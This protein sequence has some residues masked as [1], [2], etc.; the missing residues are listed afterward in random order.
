MKIIVFDTETT[1][2]P[3]NS[4]V[5]A[6]QPYI[7]QFGAMVI[8]CDLAARKLKEVQRIDQLLRPL[9]P[10]PPDASR[11]HGIRDADV[12][13]APTFAEYVDTLLG[14]FASSDAAVGHNIDFDRRII[15]NE[16]LR[17]GRRKDFLP[18]QTF[19]TM[20]AGVDVCKLPGG[21]SG[22]KY[23]TLTELHRFFFD[24][25]FANSHNAIADVMATAKVMQ[26]YMRRGIFV[27]QEPRQNSLF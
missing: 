19:D 27:P 2:F 26:E 18:A 21:R 14:F 15:E 17:V 25:E 1:G 10:I 23:P 6:D 3:S 24:V 12:V 11:V 13:A 5:L 20:L 8:E 4:G 7:C 16:L 22:Y 9:V